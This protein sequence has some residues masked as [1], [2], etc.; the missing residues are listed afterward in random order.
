MTAL[1]Q[2]NAYL[3]TLERRLRFLAISRGAALVAASALLLT[4]VFAFIGNAFAFTSR[5]VWPLR[6]LLY[7]SVA[8]AISFAL[9]RPL[10][11]LTRRWVARRAEQSIPGFRRA[12]AHGLRK[13]RSVES[14]YRAAG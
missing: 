14:L 2:L 10:L 13:R 3:Q 8:A 7:L 11:R 4:L 5:V 1:E 9:V 12:S 6:V